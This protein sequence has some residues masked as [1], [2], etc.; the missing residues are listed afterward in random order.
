MTPTTVGGGAPIRRAS[1]KARVWERI[2]GRKA[3]A[4]SLL[5]DL[6]RIPSPNPP[7]GGEKE[8]ASYCARYLRGV[9]ADVTQ[10][11]FEPGRVN[12]IGRLKGATSDRVL[13]F[14]SHLDTTPVGDDELWTHPPFGAEIHDGWLYGRGANNMK[15]GLAAAMFAQKIV[16][17]CGIELSGDILVTQTADEMNGGFVGLGELT[18]R[19]LVKADYAIYTEAHP[20][21]PDTRIEIGVRGLVEVKLRTRGHGTVFG[22]QRVNAIEKM[23]EVLVRLKDMEFRGWEPRDRP[24]APVGTIKPTV[25]TSFISGWRGHVLAPDACEAIVAVS[26]F[27][28][29]TDVT[30]MRDITEL[31][32]AMMGDDPTLQIDAHLDRHWETAFIGRDEPLVGACQRAVKEATGLTLDVGAS[33]APS[34]VR[35]LVGVAGIP[36]CKVAFGS[37]TA[38]VDERQNVDDYIKTI[39]VYATLILD[40]V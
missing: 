18:R 33:T 26:Y 3:E 6:V 36:T 31:L 22:A 19:G 21:F 29:Q 24:P 16:R 38:D 11:E 20:R 13:L 17:D 30:I 35:W 27:P 7:G 1:E 23:A 37:E 40:L 10:F 8:V 12:N 9:G 5:Q 14:A 2:D 25:S 15:V 39:K 28:P 4:I 34:D 32:G